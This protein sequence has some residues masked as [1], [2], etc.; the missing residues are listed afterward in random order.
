[1]YAQMN[2]ILAT[3]IVYDQKRWSDYLNKYVEIGRKPEV[4]DEECKSVLSEFDKKYGKY[5]VKKTERDN[6]KNY[7]LKDKDVDFNDVFDYL[8]PYTEKMRI[9]FSFQR[10][11]ESKDYDDAVAY[12]LKFPKTCSYCEAEEDDDK[13]DYFFQSMKCKTCS[14]NA[15]DFL[16]KV[17]IRS[18]F[19]VK[20]FL[21]EKIG[22]VT[23]ENGEPIVSIPLY[24]EL[25]AQGIDKE[26]FNPVFSKKE[27][28]LGY[29]LF[30]KQHILPPLSVIDGAMLS[31]RTCP[32]CGRNLMVHSITAGSTLNKRFPEFCDLIGYPLPDDHLYINRQGMEHLHRVNWTSDFFEGNRYVVVDRKLFHLITKFTPRAKTTSI[33]VFL[34]EADFDFGSWRESLH[35]KHLKEKKR[36]TGLRM[37]FEKK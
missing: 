37:P 32:D 36:P 33:P 23:T 28:L 14:H 25:I 4:F 7:I 30:G 1:M 24:H 2:L 12:V 18:D 27:D 10:K 35:I 16:E 15:H 31:K 26:F 20:K 19:S 21:C 8:E 9:D 3:H 6:W 22:G 5:K 11:Y 13:Y 29:R 34:K 17:Y